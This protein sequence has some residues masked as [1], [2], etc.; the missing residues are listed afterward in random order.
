[1]AT[2]INGLT[3]L[4][5]QYARIGEHSHPFALNPAGLHLY[6][7]ATDMRTKA[8]RLEEMLA[9]AKVEI[10]AGQRFLPLDRLAR[11]HDRDQ[12]ELMRSLLKAESQRRIFSIAHQGQVFYPNYAFASNA[13]P[14]LLTHLAQVMSALGPTKNGWDLAFW[15]RSSNNFLGNK[16]PEDILDLEPEKVLSA[17]YEEAADVMPG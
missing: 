13:G 6:L 10:L 8:E 15:F 9:L 1:M 16:R 2:L 5:K 11:L 4:L 14:D 17:A 12:G 7:E 3:F